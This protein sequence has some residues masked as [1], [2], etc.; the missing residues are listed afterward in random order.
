MGGFRNGLFQ[1]VESGKAERVPTQD[2]CVRYDIESSIVFGRQ[3]ERTQ[4]DASFFAYSKRAVEMLQSALH[5]TL[6]EMES[7]HAWTGGIVSGKLQSGNH[8]ENKDDA[9]KK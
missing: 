8:E 6:C 7:E 9:E 2:N 1:V 3:Q 4:D 5:Q